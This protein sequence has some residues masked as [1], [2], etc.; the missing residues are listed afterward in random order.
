MSD[1]MLEL[2][3]P[4]SVAILGASDNPIKA[5]GRPIDYMRR[6]GFAG[7][8][9]PVNP[10]RA[11]I[12]G[13]QAYPELAALPDAPDVVVVSVAG[14]EVEQAIDQCLAINARAAVIYSSG[15][16][17][18]GEAGAA[19]QRRLVERARAGGLR[20]FGPNTQ[21]VANFRD[22][23]ILHFSTMI[24]EEAGQDGPVAIV[25][26]SGAGSSIVYG[27]LRRK[28]I[29]VRY[30]VA[31]GNEADITAAE[32]LRAVA[33]D[34]D[35]RVLLLY[36]ESLKDPAV[37]AQAAR[38]AHQRDIPILAVK[39]G[40]TQAGQLTASSHTG[41]L[42]GEDALADAFLRQNGIQRVADFRELVEYSQVF[43]GGQ[44]PRGRKVVAI[45]NSGATCV[46]AADAAEDQG[47]AL[48][49][50]AGDGQA[51]LKAVLPSFVSARNPIDMTTA[52]LGQPHI[53]GQTL[54][55][56]AAQRQA[57][58]IY[59]G[60]PIGGEGYDFA[61]FSAQTGRFASASGVPVA[62]SANQE[63][64]AQAFRAQG[65]PV[66]DSERAAMRALGMLARHVEVNAAA[67]AEPAALP[68]VFA[69]DNAAPNVSLDEVASLAALAQAGLPVVQHRLC[70]SADDVRRALGELGT[71]VVA[72]GV[73]P[74]IT[75]KSELGLVRLG[76]AG[77]T[78]ALAAFHDLDRVLRGLSAS[79]G[80]H[81]GGVLLARQQRGAFEL[82]VG[83]H[84][85]DVY[86]PVVMVGQGGVLVEAI[87]DVQFLV[88]PFNA[89]Q[90]REAIG[91]LRI[92]RAFGA[93]RGMAAVDVDALAQMLV[94][95]GDWMVQ[96]QGQVRSVDANPV[97][98]SR[99]G[100]APVL[101]DAV[102]IRAGERS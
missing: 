38:V 68:P 58:M 41:A 29:G 11:Q 87:D 60:F 8:V 43:I 31:T 88:A 86:G 30:M 49:Q 6:Y 17:E 4:R 65:V 34:P 10:K 2:L 94:R 92:A 78:Q 75:H 35:I 85:D 97:M 20:L 36:I 53:Y 71:P 84:I 59:V 37:L 27:G 5:G 33:D 18:L 24:N 26:Q 100:V 69:K 66:F 13:L 14:Q 32:V 64:V 9:Y 23:A 83:A 79:Q 81:H 76:L 15:F 54:E 90:A 91:R 62:V 93:L 61:D 42:A 40:R 74:D 72:K 47:L 77:E 25:S 99:A 44:R 50:F 89:T 3:A 16:A 28:G 102:V 63:W 46:L 82:A 57:D 7:R 73:S 1:N 12:Q 48:C 21:G 22:G 95:L 51:A 56:V 98:V 80:I 96:A 52:L 70:R 45:S 19:Q 39:A 67:L 55:V 101:V